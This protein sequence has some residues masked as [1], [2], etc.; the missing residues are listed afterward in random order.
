[1]SDPYLGILLHEML[2]VEVTRTLAA[3]SLV[4]PNASLRSA[5][6]RNVYCLHTPPDWENKHVDC[7]V[8]DLQSSDVVPPLL[9][10]FYSGSKW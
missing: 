3:G 1:M 8:V 10:N 9:L 5:Y 6:T 7:G 2:S 4:A